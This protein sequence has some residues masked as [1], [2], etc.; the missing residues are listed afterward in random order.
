MPTSNLTAFLAYAR[1]FEL[2]W[3]TDDWS[4]V[5]A[6][7]ADDA[8]YEAHDAGPFGGGAAGRDGVVAAL[9]ESTR[10]MDRRFDVRIPEILAGPEVLP[11][12]VRMR[13]ALTLRRAGLPEL[14][15]TGTNVA[16]FAPD[17]RIATLVDT[18]DA[19][20]GARAAAYVAEHGTKLRPPGAPLATD[21]A[22]HDARDLGHAMMRSLVRCYGA[23]K[24]QQDVD[25][26]LAPCGDGFVL[27]TPAFGTTARGKDEA[28]AQLE[29]FFAVFPDYRVE[30]DGIAAE[31][32]SVAC[33]GTAHM[34]FGGPFLG[35]AP[36]GRT[37][38]VPFVSVFACDATA[39]HGERFYFDLATLCA[40]I[41]VPVAEMTG[42]LAALHAAERQ[43][44][45]AAAG[46]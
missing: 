42:A 32:R 20:A 14:C 19:G 25:A 35:L 31:G 22:P 45:T 12:G 17:G 40:Q 6:C 5:A 43:P 8:R 15:T 28:R 44:A 3:L 39:V 46:A 29:V 16:T 21:V 33:W 27:D 30:V 7:F 1:A 4:G 34:T 37:A 36:T 13:Y 2:A 11:D 18:P 23:A 9:R 41:D 38:H 24:S 26:A 10:A